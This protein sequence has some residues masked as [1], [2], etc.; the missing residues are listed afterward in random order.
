M[1]NT[2]MSITL[3]AH[4]PGDANDRQIGG[5]HYR[6]KAI[7]PWDAMSAWMSPEAFSGFLQG[8]VIKYVARYRDKGG[9][10]D[11]LK[12]RHYLDKLLE[13]TPTSGGL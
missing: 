9:R 6:T 1:S 11:L 4:P 5:T 7:Q 12:A 13:A 8:N 10:E 3:S 2:P